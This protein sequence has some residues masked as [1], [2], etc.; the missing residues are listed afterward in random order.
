MPC[1]REVRRRR[2]SPARER[3][4]AAGLRVLPYARPHLYDS[5]SPPRPQ[6]PDSTAGPVGEI[7]HAQCLHRLP[8]RQV[9]GLGGR[10]HRNVAG[11]AAP[12]I[13]ELCRGVPC[14]LD[15]PAGRRSAA[16]SDDRGFRHPRFRPRRR[17]CGT[18][19]GRGP[20]DRPG[21]GRVVGPRSDGAH[22]RARCAGERARRAA[23]A[24]GVAAPLR[25]GPRRA[26]PGRRPA[27]RIGAGQP[28][29]RGP[30]AFR[31]GGR[32]IRR[33]PAPQCRP[34]RGPRR[35]G[36]LLRPAR[37]LRRGRG[38]IQGGAAAEP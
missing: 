11:A 32:G 33:R 2:A 4:P 23:L 17:P 34:A 38:R 20:G 5:R 30:R 19:L 25:S 9:R 27:R 21:A 13:P 1:L 7:G 29:C 14:R 8:C 28:A 6:L 35:I 37:P 18:R 16:C 36:Q 22:G 3:Q 10:G 12:G 24:A 15:R 31:T 26:H